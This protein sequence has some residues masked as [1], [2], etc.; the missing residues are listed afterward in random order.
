LPGTLAATLAGLDRGAQI[1]RVHDVAEAAQALAIW[2][3]IA[4]C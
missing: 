3:A 2:R 1:H 4:G